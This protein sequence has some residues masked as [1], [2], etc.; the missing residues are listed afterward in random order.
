MYE[1]SFEVV[2]MCIAN[3]DGWL[4]VIV[5]LLAKRHVSCFS[6]DCKSLACQSKFLMQIFRRKNWFTLQSIPPF[7]ERERKPKTLF[8][9]NA[10]KPNSIFSCLSVFFLLYKMRTL[11][12]FFFSYLTSFLYRHFGTSCVDGL[13]YFVTKFFVHLKFDT[14]YCLLF[15]LL[16]L[17]S[18][19]C[20][21]WWVIGLKVGQEVYHTFLSILF[22]F[23][24][25]KISI[26]AS[27]TLH[28]I[29]FA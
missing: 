18:T 1:D 13:V 2:V 6:S 7:T 17:Q 27:H 20:F 28:P 5:Q 10:M 19:S 12:V 25:T 24:K 8:A 16:H 21:V 4:S 9:Y 22:F 3:M 15:F 26:S 23:T 29:S 11:L 14:F